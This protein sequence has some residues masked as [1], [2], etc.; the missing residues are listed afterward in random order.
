MSS[1]VHLAVYDTLADWEAGYAVAHINDPGFQREPGR[2]TVRT[3]AASAEPVTTM[4]GVRITP[5]L[6]LD[7]LRPSDS[8]MLILPGAHGWEAGGHGGMVEAARGFL[9][10]GVPVAA[11]CG[12]TGGL[13]LGGLLDGRRHTSNAREYLAGTGYAGASGYVDAPAVTDGELITASGLHPV[14]F[15]REIFARLELYEPDV[16][17]AW[18]NLFATGDPAWYGRLMEA[19]AA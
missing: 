1:T 7:E 17:E 16:L 2:Y 6:T 10:A 12:A 8:A 3:V 11:V 4:G 19:G 13:A 15:A 5:D 18:H 14:P 9:D